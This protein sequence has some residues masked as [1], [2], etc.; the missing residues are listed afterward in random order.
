MDYTIRSGTATDRGERDTNEDRVLVAERLWAVADGIGGL[1]GG[2]VASHL[3]LDSLGAAFDADP[4]MSG[5]AEA[6]R[7]ANRSV[8]DRACGSR[9]AAMGTTL[10]AVALTADAGPVVAHVGDSRLYRLGPDLELVTADH[11][12]VA[13][14]V[15]AGRL[16]EEEAAYHPHRNVLTRAVGVAPEMEAEIFPLACSPGDRLLLCTDGV[17]G[18]LG[19]EALRSA[20]GASADPR[21]V[22]AE[23]VALAVRN[24][25]TDN[26]TAL[27]LHL[28]P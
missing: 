23:V 22:A 3:A 9:D 14:M 4:T 18:V 28:S 26:A 20:L 8:W 27:V 10:T 12:V 7:E 2:E 16:S 15:R 5:L 6:C 21:R 1:P 17:S 13:E 11:T 19:P 24:G 25:A